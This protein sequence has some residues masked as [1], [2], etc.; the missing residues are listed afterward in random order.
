MRASVN[1][2]LARVTGAQFVVAQHRLAQAKTDLIKPHARAHQHRKAARADLGIERAAIAR[3]NA[4][5]LDPAIGD[6]ARQQ[7]ESAGRKKIV[8]NINKIFIYV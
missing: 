6:G 2:A 5:K 7:V 1:Q 8:Y 3:R 4:V